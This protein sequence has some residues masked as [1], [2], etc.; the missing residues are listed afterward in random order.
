MAHRGS[1]GIHAG[2]PT[3]QNL[4]SACRWGQQI[5]IKSQIKS[6][7]GGRGG[8]AA[9]LDEGFANNRRA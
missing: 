2:R 5:K 9:G 4:H 3:A 7:R 8:R 6:C 1:P